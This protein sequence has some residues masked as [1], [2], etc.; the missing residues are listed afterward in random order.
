MKIHFRTCPVR[1]GVRGWRRI[2]RQAKNISRGTLVV[3][4]GRVTLEFTN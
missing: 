4:L 1:Q 3:E 2:L